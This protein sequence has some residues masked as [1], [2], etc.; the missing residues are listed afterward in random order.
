MFKKS[1]AKTAM[2]LAFLAFTPVC[3]SAF[4]QSVT[5][6]DPVPGPYK[7]SPKTSTSTAPTASTSS[8]VD[9][10]TSAVMAL[11]LALSGA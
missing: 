8:S 6:T 4:G 10:M 2:L 1:A 3:S 7:P 5:G 9:S 11:L